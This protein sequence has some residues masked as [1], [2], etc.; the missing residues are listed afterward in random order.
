MSLLFFFK[1]LMAGDDSTNK[2]IVQEI[3]ILVSSGRYLCSSN[4]VVRI[5]TGMKVIENNLSGVCS[6]QN[7]CN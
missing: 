1:R 4:W 7:H 6:P 3:T 5:H 2:D